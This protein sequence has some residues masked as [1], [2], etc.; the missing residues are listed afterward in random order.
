MECCSGSLWQT[1]RA[2]HVHLFP[3]PRLVIPHRWFEIGHHESIHTA[4]VGKNYELAVF[5]PSPLRA[6]YSVFTSTPLLGTLPPPLTHCTPHPWQSSGATLH[7]LLIQSSG[8]GTCQ[9]AGKEE[10]IPE[11]GDRDQAPSFPSPFWIS[12][13]PSWLLPAVLYPGKSSEAG[14]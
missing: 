5:T 14:K 1:A 11:A 2:S 12:A 6:G 8:L 9:G 10:G 13:H 7:I 3:A 4:E